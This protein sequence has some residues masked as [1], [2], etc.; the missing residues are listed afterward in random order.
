VFKG[1][2][3]LFNLQGNGFLSKFQ[4]KKRALLAPFFWW[5]GWLWS[6][7]SPAHGRA[8]KQKPNIFLS[9]MSELLLP[10]FQPYLEAKKRITIIRM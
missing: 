10:S 9:E 8:V 5:F 6:L 4:D 7:V 1:S 3:Y 2:K